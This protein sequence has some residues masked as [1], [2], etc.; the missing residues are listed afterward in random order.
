MFIVFCRECGHKVET[1]NYI[2]FIGKECEMCGSIELDIEQVLGDNF[3]VI[4]NDI[5]KQ[6]K[7]FSTNDFIHLKEELKFSKLSKIT[8]QEIEDFILDLELKTVTELVKE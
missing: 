3:P 5:K 4:H 8:K 6:N 7:H 2:D 1:D